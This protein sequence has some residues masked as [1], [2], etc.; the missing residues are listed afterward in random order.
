LSSPNTGELP[1]TFSILRTARFRL[2]ADSVQA[3]VTRWP[4]KGRIVPS[5][6]RKAVRRDPKMVRFRGEPFFTAL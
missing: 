6:F 3:F 4:K 2:F 1:D 5:R